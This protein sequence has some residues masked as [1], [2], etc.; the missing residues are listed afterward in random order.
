MRFV[1]W[2]PTYTTIKMLSSGR[3]PGGK[4]VQGLH[5]VGTCLE[6]E[7]HNKCR[8]E[9]AMFEEFKDDNDGGYG[10]HEIGCIQWEAK[11]A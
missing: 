9:R 10:Y 8:L 2:I 4:R 3:L 11:Y 7:T 1:D 6:C 5:V